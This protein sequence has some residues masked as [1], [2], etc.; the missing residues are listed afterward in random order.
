MK[1]L[2]ETLLLVLLSVCLFG[3][4]KDDSWVINE[5]IH[6]QENEYAK[7]AFDGAL[8][9]LDGAGYEYIGL[10]ARQVTAGTSYKILAKQTIREEENLVIVTVYDSF[11]GPV[12]E[13]IDDL[14][15]NELKDLESH[16]INRNGQDGGWHFDTD[17]KL[18]DIDSKVLNI[19]NSLISGMVGVGYTP[20]DLLANTKNEYALLVK[21][22]IMGSDPFED[23]AIVFFNKKDIINVYVFDLNK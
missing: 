10:I 7:K 13:N 21:E 20:I 18:Q 15:L 1:K 8:A 5:N 14:D 16:S 19:F 3:C 22:K 12:L 4:G 2:L 17:L 6:P 11:D 23:Y 9:G